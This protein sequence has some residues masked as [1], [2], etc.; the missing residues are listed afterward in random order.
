[1]NQADRAQMEAIA[2]QIT[3]LADSVKT[4]T[5]PD[6]ASALRDLVEVAP[7]LKE[8]ANHA[9]TLEDLADGYRMAGKAGNF[10]KW[11]ASVAAGIGGI[12]AFFRFVIF[13]SPK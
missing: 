13:G 7:A 11:M 1:M 3:A 6:T 12:W 2:R 9:P 5:D 10:V 8:L 4:L